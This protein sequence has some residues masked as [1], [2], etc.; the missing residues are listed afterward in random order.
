VTTWTYA[1]TNL[2]TG[3]VLSDSLPL[4]VQNFS[5]ALNGGGTLTGALDLDQDFKVNTPWVAALEARKCVLWALADGY[6]A[7]NGVVW[8]WP[9]TTRDSGTL[10]IAGQTMDFIWSKRRITSDLVYDNVDLFTAFIDLLT[11]GVTKTSPYITDGSGPVSPLVAAGARVAGLV[12]PQGA[13][14]L[15]GVPWSATYAAAD[16]TQVSQAWADMTASGNLEFAFVPGL[17]GSGN[18]VTVLQLGYT[19]LGRPTPESGYELTYPGNASDYGYQRT[20]SQGANAIWA[21]APPNGLPGNWQS[22][23]PHGYDLDDLAAGYP[24]M[25]DTYS[26]PGSVVSQQSQIDGYADGY[27]AM[28]TQAM[29]MPVI[30]VAAGVKPSVTDLVLGDTVPFTATSPLHPP[31][32]DG[33]PGLQQLVRVASWTVTPPGD[34]QQESLQIATSGVLASM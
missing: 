30:K 9:D 34:N 20:G 1:A 27:V 13:A 4:A 32:P 24:L 22:A 16:L 11:Y 21:T 19:Q 25:E 15:C 6:P 3:Q 23:Y 2:L 26:W 18:L 5:N 7:W 8:D 28:R 33:S 10:P 12:L 31:R 17:D 14:A 29:T